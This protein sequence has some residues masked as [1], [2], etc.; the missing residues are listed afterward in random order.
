M[1]QLISVLIFLM[2]YSC[3]PVRIAPN[4]KGDKI[5]K[6][7]RFKRDLPRNY[8]FVF[9]D[10][11]DANEF[12]NFIN[13]KFKLDYIDVESNVPI[14]VEEETYFLSFYER[15]KVTKTINL[16]PILVDAKRESN[17][18]DPIMEDVHTSRN[19]KWYLI[20]IVLDSEMNDGLSPNY[21]KKDKILSYLRNLQHEYL[22]T[23]NYLESYLRSD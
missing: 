13:M 3:I 2:I 6:A 4:I 17:G 9:E 22:T 12:Y 18:N 7:K 21:Q 10:P 15:E 16:L 5:V 20:L 23:H 19:G 1:R 8:G 11:K 14:K